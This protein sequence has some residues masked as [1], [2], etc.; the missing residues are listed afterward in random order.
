MTNY[1]CSIERGNRVRFGRFSLF[2]R[3]GLFLR[4]LDD[5]MEIP[6][7]HLMIIPSFL[8]PSN[9]RQRDRSEGDP[10][11]KTIPAGATGMKVTRK[12]GKEDMKM[13]AFLKR[14]N[15]KRG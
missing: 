2:R 15:T 1:P 7:M 5:I 10:T 13:A 12:A 14:E 8:S 6:A 9:K 11:Q 3:I 4:L